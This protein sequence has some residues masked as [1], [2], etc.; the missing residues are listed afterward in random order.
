MKITDEIFQVGGSGLT[1]P[2]DAAIYMICFDGHAALVDGGC[3]YASDRLLANIR[4]HGILPEKMQWLLLTHCHFDHTGGAAFLR[5]H[6]H[7]QVVMH[8]SD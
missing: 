3:G 1:S 4:S 8:E 7:C 5:E 6:L 2:E